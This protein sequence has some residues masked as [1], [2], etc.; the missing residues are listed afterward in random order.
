MSLEKLELPPDLSWQ[1][2]TDLGSELVQLALMSRESIKPL[3]VVAM[4]KPQ[5]LALCLRLMQAIEQLDEI[6]PERTN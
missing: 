6:R 4:S 2:G 1:V 5:S 3:A